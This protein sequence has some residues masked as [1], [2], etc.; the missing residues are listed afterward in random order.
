MTIDSIIVLIGYIILHVFS[1]A[2][3][4]SCLS[5]HTRKDGP[6]RKIRPIWMALYI[7]I[8][9]L[10]ILG[11]FWPESALKYEIMKY[12]NIWIGFDIYYCGFLLIFTIIDRVIRNIRSRKTEITLQPSR[13]T[14]ILA[15]I[16]A[17]ILPSYAMVHAQHPV[18]T[19][20]TADLTKGEQEKGTYRVVLLAD[21]HMS[22]NSDP[23]LIEK[24]VELSNAQD[25]DAVFIVGDFF[26]SNYEG[27]KEPEK[28]IA[29][30]SQLSAKE[31][32]FGVYGNH[33]VKENLF[34]GFAVAPVSK[35]F[36]PH[37]M[38]EFLEACGFIMLE[39]GTIEIAGGDIVLAGRYDKDRVGD[40]TNIRKN[41]EELLDGID[42]DRM[43]FVLEHEPKDYAELAS[44]GVDV[45]FSGH[46]HR[47]QIWPCNYFIGLF[48][49]NAYGRKNVNG[50]ETFVTSGIGY[51]GPPQR[52]GTDS[53]V[54][55]IDITY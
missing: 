28:Y 26:T 51:F 19:Y 7:L 41:A 23:A 43:I 14:L 33:D 18:V 2:A 47:G 12:G 16:L 4:E 5:S 52:S 29:A 53:E 8:S 55:V 49:E 21:F 38:E 39:D 32:V 6:Y 44:A 1:V 46:T 48:N 22:V 50:M 17:L 10:P 34:C 11:T 9:V 30:L 3:T 37:E 40:G 15:I 36:R 54:M 42:P 25:A 45:A 35:A 13:W 20:W 24:T 31:G 27:L